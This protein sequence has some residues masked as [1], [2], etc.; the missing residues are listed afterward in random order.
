MTRIPRNFAVSVPALLAALLMCS[1]ATW[2][3]AQY[4][5][6][7]G[8]RTGGGGGGG[9]VNPQ[10]SRQVNVGLQGTPMTGSVRYAPTSVAMPSEV[11]NAYWQSGA[12]PSDIRMGYASLGPL[13][14]GGA[15]DY[16]PPKPDYL[17][18]PSGAPPAAM[19]SGAYSTGSVRYA[20]TSVSLPFTASA[21]AAP[22]GAAP[23]T[24]ANLAGRSMTPVAPTS[25]QPINSGPMN[26]GPRNT[27][28][29]RYAR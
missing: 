9:Q 14:P 21:S 17:T 10:I 23:I 13:T 8:A 25:M 28:V 4:Q 1:A 12:L 7:T 26:S 29:V 6:S 27:G 24:S 5:V 11:R 18:K 19:G 22:A 16:I 2:L 3:V 20:P 15:M